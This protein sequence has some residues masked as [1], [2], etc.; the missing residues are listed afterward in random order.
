MLMGRVLPKIRAPNDNCARCV[1]GIIGSY[2]KLFFE[3]DPKLARSVGFWLASMPKQASVDPIIT[4]KSLSAY[5][6]ESLECPS[7]TA[8]LASYDS[9]LAYLAKFTKDP[10][11]GGALGSFVSMGDGLEV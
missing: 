4:R 2:R 7:E 9:R 3:A 11:T 8:W 5:E 10:L 1:A 6:S